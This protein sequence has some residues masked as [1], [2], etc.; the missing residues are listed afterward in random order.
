MAITTYIP[1]KIATLIE[2]DEDDNLLQNSLSGVKTGAIAS[3]IQTVIYPS[4]ESVYVTAAADTGNGGDD[5]VSLSYVPTRSLDAGLG[6]DTL[7]L[8]RINSLMA[9]EGGEYGDFFYWT[10]ISLH[11]SKMVFYSSYPVVT[12]AIRNFENVIGTCLPDRLTGSNK[13]NILSGGGCSDTIFGGGGNDTLSGGFWSDFVYGQDGNDLIV[14]DSLLDDDL[15]DGGSGFDQVDYSLAGGGRPIYANLATGRVEK[16]YYE[17]YY[18]G[19]YRNDIYTLN[20]DTLRS[21]ESIIGTSYNDTLAGG[22]Y[23][24]NLQA[25]AGNDVIS[26]NAGNDSL[27]G[28][29]G[30]DSINGDSG[31]DLL[32]GGAGDDTVNGGTGN[33]LM[34]LDGGGNDTFIF[35]A[36]FGK[37]KIVCANAADAAGTDI[38]QLNSVDATK[39]FFQRSANDLNVKIVGKS[40]VLTL[41]NWFGDPVTATNGN[42]GFHIDQF[43][44]GDVVVSGSL[45]D[46]FVKVV[47]TSPVYMGP[48]ADYAATLG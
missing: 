32:V 16:S 46:Q 10:S 40:D 29:A 3:G 7:D 35:D 5:W 21:I 15:F 12:T 25:G 20:V 19:G 2:D 23:A 9:L 43:K 39:V 8:S 33:D 27:S 47:G 48:L 24:D 13:A 38:V 30:N 18:I 22:K 36:A 4:V 37:D 1:Q 41:V 42:V 28:M 45:V 14:Q 31:N 34:R 44:A 26:G 6:N 17:Y 11:T